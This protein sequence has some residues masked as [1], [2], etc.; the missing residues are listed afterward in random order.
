MESCELFVGQIEV[1]IK[2]KVGIRA[3]LYT[4]DQNESRCDHIERRIIIKLFD[5][6]V[7]P[8]LKLQLK[9]MVII[10]GEISDQADR[11]SKRV[12]IMALK[13]RV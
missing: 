12:N 3:L 10:M 8:F 6:D 5:S 7:D 4:I 9:E 2:K 11:I 13:R 1:M